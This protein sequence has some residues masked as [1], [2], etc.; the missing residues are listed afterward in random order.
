MKT[1][2]INF[3]KLSI[4]GLQTQ[5]LRVERQL[6]KDTFLPNFNCKIL[7]NCIENSIF[8]HASINRMVT[9]N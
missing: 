5:N 9:P 3:F 1:Q 7:K 8:T 6:L 2:F 4:D